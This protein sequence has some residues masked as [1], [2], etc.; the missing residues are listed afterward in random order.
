MQ[1]RGSIKHPISKQKQK[2][3]ERKG[4]DRKYEQVESFCSANKAP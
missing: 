2:K 1:K 3:K 4:D